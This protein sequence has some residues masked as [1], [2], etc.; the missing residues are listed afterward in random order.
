M[1]AKEPN[2]EVLSVL[3]DNPTKVLI[4]AKHGGG[5]PSPYQT[6]DGQIRIIAKVKG[7]R[8]KVVFE[9]VDPDDPSPYPEDTDH[10]TIWPQ[11]EGLVMDDN[12]ND[13]RD[14][15]RN[16][17][18]AYETFQN[19]CLRPKQVRIGDPNQSR[20]LPD[21]TWEVWTNLLITDRF[22]G[23]NYIVRATCEEV[24]AGKYF[25]EQPKLQG[26]YKESGL[27]TAWKRVY[28]E[29]DKMYKIG[30]DLSQDANVGDNKIFVRFARI[31]DKEGNV[32]KLLPSQLFE[33]NDLVVIFDANN[34]NGE[35]ITI[36]EINDEEMSITFTPALQNSYKCST[37]DAYY[38]DG[39]GAAVGKPSAG[40]W[41]VDTSLIQT[42]LN[43]C[44]VDIVFPNEGSNAVPFKH[45]PIEAEDP[46]RGYIGVNHFSEVWFAH[47]RKRGPFNN[48]IHL[49]GAY[50]WGE[51]DR[52]GSGTSPTTTDLNYSYVFVAYIY[53][54]YTYNPKA[55][56][57]EL[58]AH[59]IIHQWQFKGTDASDPHEF[60]DEQGIKRSYCL[61]N[62]KQ[63][64]WDEI[65][66]LWHNTQ[67]LSDRSPMI[68]ETSHVYYIRD[69]VDD[70]YQLFPK[71]GD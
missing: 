38:A 57:R 67:D 17:R 50:Q 6:Q 11:I 22:A 64:Y 8:G 48:Y 36:I 65:V 16:G 23:D 46:E 1:S 20:R 39:K 71:E 66:R 59:E 7:G 25:H 51:K 69:S 26:K 42:A 13:N 32:I 14:P 4:S 53:E 41:E 35:Q 63:S 58:V 31:L 19:N 15:N 52:R 55:F 49:V 54:M 37:D 68:P 12:P 5:Y 34:P 40:F 18:L 30:T 9:V 56:L 10:D 62:Y 29:V 70:L 21:G 2:C 28:C 33:P 43:Q 60:E 61:M 45:F 44:F 24:E 47:D 3:P 27:L